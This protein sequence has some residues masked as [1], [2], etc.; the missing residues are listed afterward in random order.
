MAGFSTTQFF[1]NLPLLLV[2]NVPGRLLPIVLPRF[3]LVYALM[4][5]YQFRRG[6]ARPALRG[7][8]AVRRSRRR[9]VPPTAGDPAARGGSPSARSESCS[10]QGSHPG[11][12]CCVVA[13][14]RPTPRTLRRLAL[15]AASVHHRDHR[16]GRPSS[17]GV[18][19]RSWATTCTGWSRGRT[20]RRP[21]RSIE[22][23]P[24]VELVPGDLADLPS[25][26]ASLE[27]SQPDEVYNLG[28]ISFVASELLAGRADGEH[29]RPRGAADARGD[30]HGRGHA[31]QPDPLLP[32]VVVGD[33]RQGPRD[34][35]G[36]DD[37]VPSAFAVRLRQGVRA[38]HHGELPG[39]LRAVRLFRDPV[40]P[41]GTASGHRVRHPQ[42]DQRGGADQARS[43]ARA[44]DG[45]ARHASAT[46]DMP[47]TTCGRCG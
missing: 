47:A 19:S 26:V 27:L 7:V 28:A 40:Q 21:P 18:P 13:C 44:G 39:E 1:R 30:P 3:A 11:C 16:P 8:L 37:A 31:E 14:G 36:R 45:H 5:L 32:G 4:V 33:V 15:R 34:A 22:E 43:A 41:R 23:M 6:Q 20:T 17:G 46:G 9:R 12:G 25:L 42:G 24:F 10:G 38:R 35:A 29:D 2:N